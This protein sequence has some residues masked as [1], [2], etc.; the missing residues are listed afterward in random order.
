VTASKT[1]ES[2][3]TIVCSCCERTIPSDEPNGMCWECRGRPAVYGYVRKL[4]GLR[5]KRC[6]HAMPIGRDA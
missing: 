4:A 6:Q 1:G 5:H 3:T 2:V